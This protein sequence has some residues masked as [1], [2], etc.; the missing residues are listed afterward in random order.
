MKLKIAI[1]PYSRKFYSSI[2]SLAILLFY[3]VNSPLQV[4]GQVLPTEDRT[5]E[6]QFSPG[7]ILIRFK[8]EPVYYQLSAIENDLNGIVAEKIPHIQWRVMHVAP[9][10]EK[11]ALKRALANPNVSGAELDYKFKTST[12]ISPDFMNS[13]FRTIVFRIVLLLKDN[14][15]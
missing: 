6:T 3:L 4:S 5:S 15:H 1:T 14:G 7:V 13:R 11:N 12:S 9:G 8:Q 2:V 10:Q